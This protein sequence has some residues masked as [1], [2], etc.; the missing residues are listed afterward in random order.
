M[1][2]TVVSMLKTLLSQPPHICCQVVLLVDNVLATAMHA[3]YFMVSNM[4]QA[5][6]GGLM[7]S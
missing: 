4:L 3:L 5:I 1:H 7:F 6:P 2:Q